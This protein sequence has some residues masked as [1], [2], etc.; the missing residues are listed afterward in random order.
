[1]QGSIGVLVGARVPCGALRVGNGACRTSMAVHT[2]VCLTHCLLHTFFGWVWSGLQHPRHVCV[3][4]HSMR[5][6]LA[7]MHI[8]TRCPASYAAPPQIAKLL[9]IP[10]V[11]MVELVWLRKTFTAPIIASVL[12]VIAGVSI[13]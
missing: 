7:L 2:H 4:M 1:M 13:V 5:T 8:C 3:H 10:F 12:T 9:I 6:A 11:C